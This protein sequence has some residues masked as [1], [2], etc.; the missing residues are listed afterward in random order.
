MPTYQ[1]KRKDGTTFEILQRITDEPLKTC[2]ETGQKVERIVTGGGGVIYKGS[3]WYVTDYKNKSN[4]GSSGPAAKSVNAN[5]NDSANSDSKS[6]ND[7]SNAGD[8]KGT[9]DSSSTDRK[10]SNGSGETTKPA[11]DKG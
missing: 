3:G 5:S 4:G 9:G 11:T 10:G 8:S 2:P 6:G 7:N 1:Y